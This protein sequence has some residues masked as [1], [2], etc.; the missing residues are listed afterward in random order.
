MRPIFFVYALERP[1]IKMRCFQLYEVLSKKYTI[2]ICH[3]DDPEIM[4]IKDSIIFFFKHIIPFYKTLDF[5]E[6]RKNNNVLIYDTIDLTHGRRKFYTFQDGF[7]NDLDYVITPLIEVFKKNSNNSKARYIPH[8]Y[9]LGLIDIKSNPNKKNE[10][11]YQGNK[12]YIKKFEK[13]LDKVEKSFIFSDF[14][15]NI[16]YYT[17]FRFHISFYDNNL[18]DSIYKPITKIATAAALEAIPICENSEEN[19]YWLGEDYPFYIDLKNKRES[20]KYWIDKIYKNNID[21]SLIDKAMKKMIPLRKKLNLHNIVQEYYIPLLDEINNNNKKQERSKEIDL[22]SA[23]RK[24]DIKTDDKNLIKWI[25]FMK[26]KNRYEDSD[27]KEYN[28]IIKKEL[29][30]IMKNNLS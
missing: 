15:K 9:D 12:L 4:T 26:K 23:L 22:L 24:L 2:K 1:S 21:N 27:N 7:Y 28:I 29:K 18:I 13:L 25:K 20:I 8:H 6:L 11:L 17:S 10:I 3:L 16:N 14:I 19:V 5:S 30:K